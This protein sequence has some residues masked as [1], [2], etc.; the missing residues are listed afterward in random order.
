MLAF[1]SSSAASSS[2]RSARSCATANPAGRLPV[3]ALRC[4]LARLERRAAEAECGGTGTE[5]R[6][7]QRLEEGEGDEEEEGGREEE[8]E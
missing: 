7:F 5:V 2:L 1:S 8:A 3:R 6:G 4:A